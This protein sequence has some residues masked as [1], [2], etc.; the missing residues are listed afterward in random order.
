MITGFK[1]K[2]GSTTVKLEHPED[3]PEIDGQVFGAWCAPPGENLAVRSHGYL[4]SKEK[5]PSPGE[6]YECSNV[7]IFESP[8]RY[9]DMARRV[10]LPKR[11]V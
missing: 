7:D 1:P 8:H 6:L 2:A 11:G 3:S 10:E 9:P 4:T 5:V